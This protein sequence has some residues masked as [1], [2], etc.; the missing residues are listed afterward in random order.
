MKKF[1][2]IRTTTTEKVLALEITAKTIEEAQEMAYNYDE[3]Q[4]DNI[5]ELPD[6]W[7]DGDTVVEIE[8]QE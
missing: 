2:A 1:K 3:T 5:K 8:E 6:G 4:S 7:E